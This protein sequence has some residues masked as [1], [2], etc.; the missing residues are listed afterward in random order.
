VKIR[1]ESHGVARKGLFVDLRLGEEALTDDAGSIRELDSASALRD[2]LLQVNPQL[3]NS[4]RV[5][6]FVQV[7]R[8]GKLRK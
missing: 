6:R 5:I 3:I 1:T 4:S 2:N 8:G 7:T